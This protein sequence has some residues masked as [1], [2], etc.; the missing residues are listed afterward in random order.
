MQSYT[1]GFTLEQFRSDRKTIDAVERNFIL[2]GEAARYVPEDVT[3]RHTAVPWRKMRD[4][5]N[6]VVHGY[7]GVDLERMWD[8]IQ[9][10]LP[11]LVPLL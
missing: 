9:Q 5:R 8:T 6:I 1:Q 10:D 11:P 2:I 4:M 3:E 7:W